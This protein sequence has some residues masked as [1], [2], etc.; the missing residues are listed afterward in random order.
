L[1]N[2]TAKAGNIASLGRESSEGSLTAEITLTEETL[3]WQAIRVRGV[4]S[5]VDGPDTP[6]A[7]WH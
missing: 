3:V 7:R 2:I 5:E 4:R 1:S 6:V